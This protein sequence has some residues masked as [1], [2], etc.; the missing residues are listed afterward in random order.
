MLQ[1]GGG[2]AKPE[3]PGKNMQ[4]GWVNIVDSSLQEPAYLH[5]ANVLIPLRHRGAIAR[6]GE[7]SWISP[8]EKGAF[9]LDLVVQHSSIL[10]ELRL[11]AL[12]YLRS[13]SDHHC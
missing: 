11:F 6:S 1:P 13:Y 3:R 8:L 10:H 2:A 4:L 5:D 12:S 7:I 9:A